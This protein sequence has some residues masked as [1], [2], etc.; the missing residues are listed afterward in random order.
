M[1][2]GIGIGGGLGAL[3]ISTALEVYYWLPIVDVD[4]G[5]DMGTTHNT[6]GALLMVDIGVAGGLGADGIHIVLRGL[7][8]TEIVGRR[9]RPS[10]RIV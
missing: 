2:I 9:N 4:V 1:V 8:A 7:R 3:R 10:S 5:L 6:R